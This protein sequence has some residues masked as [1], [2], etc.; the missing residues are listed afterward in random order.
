[1]AGSPPKPA[2]LTSLKRAALAHHARKNGG[3]FEAVAQEPLAI[4]GL[5]LRTPGAAT[6]SEFEDLVLSGRSA[7]GPLPTDRWDQAAFAALK[8]ADGRPM[9]QAGGF[10]DDVKGF[11]AAAFRMSGAEAAALDPQ[12]RLLLELALEALETSG[13]AAQAF[14]GSSTGVWLGLS[15]HD[16]A[17]RWLMAR[18]AM[19]VTAH[20]GTGTQATFAPGRI[21][22]FLGLNGPAQAIDTACSSGLVALAE[23]ATALRA[24]RVDRALV[25]AAHLILSPGGFLYNMLVGALAPDGVSKAFAEG[26]DGFGRGEGGVMLVVERLSDAIRENRLIWSVIRSVVTGQDGASGGL[27]VPSGPAQSALIASALH[28]AGLEP[29]DIDLIE[30]HGTGTDLGDPIELRALSQ[31]LGKGR[32]RPLP[33]G[34]IKASIGHL[35]AA[36]GLVG[37]AKAL[38]AVRAGDVP[39]TLQCETPT[40]R[41][42]WG[43]LGLVPARAARDGVRR[44]GVSSFGMSGTNAHAILEAPPKSPLPASRPEWRKLPLTLSGANADK[45]QE[46]LRRLREEIGAIDPQ[47]RD[48]FIDHI[49]GMPR[50]T[51]HGSLRVSLNVASAQAAADAVTKAKPAPRSNDAPRIA[52]LFSGQGALLGPQTLEAALAL[53]GMRARL[54]FARG[55]L[56]AHIEPDLFDLLANKDDALAHTQF[57]QPAL[58]ALG[59]ALFAWW[60]DLGLPVDAVAGHSLGELPA[61]VAA[62]HLSAQD[63]LVFAAERGRLMG[64]CPPGAMALVATDPENAALL[65]VLVSNEALEIAG[66]NGPA[67]TVIAGPEASIERALDALGKIGVSGQKLAV[68]RA[69]HSAL[70]ALSL[71]GIEAAA[72]RMAP[73][74][75][76]RRTFFSTLAGGAAQDAPITLDAAYWREQA[77]APVAFAPAVEAME[78]AGITHFIDIGAQPLLAT[79]ARRIAPQA[80]VLSARLDQSGALQ[81][82][83]GDLWAQGVDLDI[84]KLWQPYRLGKRPQMAPVF[85]RK[86]YWMEE[87][88]MDDFKAQGSVSASAPASGPSDLQ[89]DVRATIADALGMAPEELGPETELIEIGADS[90]AL[91]EIGRRIKAQYGVELTARQFFE[92]CETIGDIASHIEAEISARPAA[93]AL[94]APSMDQRASAPEVAAQTAAPVP[95][96]AAPAHMP[97]TSEQ[98]QLFARQLDLVRDVIASQNAAMGAAHAPVVAPHRSGEPPQIAPAPAAPHEKAPP[99]IT[100]GPFR[101]P[102]RVAGPALSSRQKAHLDDLVARYTARTP[103]SKRLAEAARPTLA[104]ARA[105]AGFRPSI[106]E[107]LYPITGDRAKGAHLWD[108]DGNEYIDISMNFG[109]CLFGHGHPEME[110]AITSAVASGLAMAP[111]SPH[112]A[113][114]A[115]KLCRMTGADRAVFLQSGTEAVMTAVRLARLHTG[116]DKIALF[117]KSY[118]GHSDGLLAMAG[119]DEAAPAD[120]VTS[121]IPASLVEDVIVL[122]YGD[123]TAL[124]RVRARGA[125]L[126]AVLVEPVQSRDIGNHP[127]G[128]L[129]DLRAITEASGTL[130]IF[131]E[132]ITGFRLA[133]GGAQAWYGLRADIACYGKALGGGVAVGAVAGRADIL[134]GIDGGQWAYGDAS[135]P[136]APTTFVAGTFNGN[137]LALAAVDAAL[138][139]MEREGPALQERIN[140]RTRAFAERMNTWL[141]AREI[142]LRIVL[143]G[144]HFRFQHGGNLDLLYY[145]LLLRGVFVWEGRNCFLSAAHGEAE[146]RLLEERLKDAVLALSEGGFIQERDVPAGAMAKRITPS[147][148]QRQL[149]LLDARGDDVAAAYVERLAVEIRGPLDVSALA[150]AVAALPAR[151]EALRASFSAAGDALDIAA[152]AAATLDIQE[153]QAGESREA[154]LAA[155]ASARLGL[156]EAPAARFIWRQ[157]APDRGVLLLAAHHALFDGWSLAVVFA[158]LLALIERPDAPMP[159][160][161]MSDVLADMDARRTAKADTLAAYWDD[162]LKDLPALTLPHDRVEG[163]PVIHVRKEVPSEAAQAVKRFAKAIKATPF[164]AYLG[165]THATLGLWAG[166]ERFAIGCPVLGRGEAPELMEAAAYAT[167]ILPVVADHLPREGL[168]DTVKRV[169]DS[170]LSALDHQDLPFAD[171]VERYGAGG[172]RLISVTFNLDRPSLPKAPNDLSVELL[173]VAPRAAK[174]PICINMLDLGGRLLLDVDADGAL[175]SQ[176]AVETLAERLIAGFG[177][178]ETHAEAP[179]ATLAQADRKGLAMVRGFSEGPVR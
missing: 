105:S 162:A 103:Q 165:L 84:A 58:A 64:A 42:D 65:D 89:S 55:V 66:R 40:S 123:P 138:T 25:G 67:A 157:E 69:F 16:Y 104:D 173:D 9:P 146:I 110:A 106:K 22:Y 51:D 121:G 151:H 56:A 10:L 136:K 139:I 127:K 125:S 116:R 166:A 115:E 13:L 96:Q 77:R 72:S 18:E 171:L 39:P 82:L 124:E 23:A 158:D 28:E 32:A 91:V 35:E 133:Q 99:A 43:A 164:A 50:D 71:P 100:H 130:M 153:A 112:L 177:A 161:Q 27:T 4:T 14:K 88:P 37:L 160:A 145:H 38:V 41:V 86:D 73:R 83:A 167:H 122:D 170:L 141:S 126:A 60:E 1:M 102:S 47:D 46:K 79:M 20:F 176:E 109:V 45:L 92:G 68:T 135:R 143:A 94:A 111:R 90:L 95:S 85:N 132:M 175:F 179:V 54:T 93:A 30:A 168:S 120:P 15:S 44:V 128:F 169:R 59:W 34:S 2:P 129:Q 17:D 70:M 78:K 159:A 152:E 48:A 57:A 49:G 5:A 172:E 81:C 53:D 74:E 140:A 155:A 108:I 101:P 19:P 7:I 147:L 154:W 113:P 131:D 144:S 61:A 97:A 8:D 174:F 21:A 148:A 29:G 107:L 150:R 6:I 62:G 33:V 75:G 149:W 3:P 142:D 134:D 26:A 24:Q 63:M 52:L 119:I 12:H 98:A 11:D 31:V 137:P 114:A 76:A 178:C 80:Q 163:P 117:G 118:H 156:N 36:A 87:T